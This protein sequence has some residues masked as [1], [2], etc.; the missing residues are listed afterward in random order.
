VLTG[1]TEK[2]DTSLVTQGWVSDKPCRVI[3]VTGAYVTVARPDIAAGWPERQPDPGFTLHT[4]SEESLLIS[5]EDLLTLTPG[6]VI[7]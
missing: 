3:V 7:L 2:A 5:K 1:S 6:G 4:V